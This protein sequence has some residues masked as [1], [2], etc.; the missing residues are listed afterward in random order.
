[1]ASSLLETIE[2][3]LANPVLTRA[4]LFLL[5]L[6]VLEVSQNQTA[7]PTNNKEIRISCTVLFMQVVQKKSRY[8]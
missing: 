8:A 5:R 3:H 4:F 6:K 2:E 7:C 1:M